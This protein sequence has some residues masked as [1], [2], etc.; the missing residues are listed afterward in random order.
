MANMATEIAVMATEIAAE[1]RK[2]G[3]VRGTEHLVGKVRK[4]L[5]YTYP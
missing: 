5:G 2:A 1:A 4:A 3:G